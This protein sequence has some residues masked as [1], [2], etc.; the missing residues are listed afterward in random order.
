MWLY[1]RNFS[2]RNVLILTPSIL[3]GVAIATV[4]TPYTSESA[5]L[6]FTGAIGLWFCLKVW[7]KKGPKTQQPA[8]LLPGIFW[9][10]F[11]G[12]ASFITHSGAPPSQAYLLPQQ[13]PKLTLAG[14]IAI[15][16]AIG[17]LAKL[18]A[19]FAIGQLEGL[20][21]PLIA[22][23]SVTGVGGVFVGRWLTA[24]VAQSTYMR[25]IYI[26]LFSL[27]IILL[28][29]GAVELLVF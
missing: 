29:R 2:K 20:N 23:L 26:T 6:I 22:G 21:W 27:S 1:R 10:C 14:S 25:I 28:L 15:S 19:Y 18:P 13:L 8:R 5:L 16:F 7:L 9:G 12:I 17:N 11:T 24:V 3:L 4:I